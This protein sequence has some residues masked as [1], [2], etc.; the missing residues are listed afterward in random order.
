MSSLSAPSYFFTREQLPPSRSTL[1]TYPSFNFPFI[2]ARADTDERSKSSSESSATREEQF[3]LSSEFGQYG[4]YHALTRCLGHHC[5]LFR[6]RFQRRR[7]EAPRCEATR[8]ERVSADRRR[9]RRRQ[10]PRTPT[11]T[12]P[13]HRPAFE[14]SACERAR[15]P[16]CE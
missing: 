3:G 7:R 2:N 1:R 4:G 13:S 11:L 15:D 16:A 9:R 6:G 5:R 14:L 8:R 10:R 12:R